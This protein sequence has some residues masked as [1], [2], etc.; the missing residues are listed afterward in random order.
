M[1]PASPS[2]CSRAGTPC[3]P[4][5][6]QRPSRTGYRLSLRR[7]CS[8]TTG[9]GPTGVPRRTR[10]RRGNRAI[11][12]RRRPSQCDSEKRGRAREQRPFLDCDA[13]AGRH[14]VIDQER[15]GARCRRR[16]GGTVVGGEGA[17]G[18]LPPSPHPLS[19][20]AAIAQKPT[21]AASGG[22]CMSAERRVPARSVSRV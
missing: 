4:G 19:N 13:V 21:V 7:S 14:S 12:Q 5:A 9:G 1:R 11:A 20:A 18:V 3:P 6:A 22:R 8:R 16:H 15:D 2:P 10:S 17:V